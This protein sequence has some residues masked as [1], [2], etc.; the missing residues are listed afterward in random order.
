MV[1]HLRLREWM[2][3]DV[4]GRQDL[5]GDAARASLTE[6]GVF[7]PATAH[8]SGWLW[9]MLGPG[10]YLTGEGGDE[11]LGLRRTSPL[12]EVL[13]Y[14]V[15]G[16]RLPTPTIARATR[17]S[18]ATSRRRARHR[19]AQLLEDYG[20]A[21]LRPDARARLVDLAARG[22]ATEPWRA[23]PWLEQHLARRRVSI[24][25]HNVQ[26]HAASHGIAWKAPLLDPRF[27]AALATRVPWH[28]YRGRPILLRHHFADLLPPLLRERTTKATFNSAFFGDDTR[29]F[30]TTWDGS[31]LPASVDT[32]WLR[33]N[34][35][36][37]TPHAGTAMLLQR[38]WSA[39]C[40]GASNSPVA[41]T[42][43]GT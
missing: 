39:T 3:V 31:G 37:H 43:R 27:L 16:H 21:W 36:S 34:W 28:E 5:L 20:A 41:V 9:D 18:F 33:D 26:C 35:L 38:A 8:T 13:R 4:A 7:W 15:R 22:E 40:A 42:T 6:H 17:S 32:A 30:A 19:R 23:R 2:V 29:Q 25:L 24:G 14:A 10:T 1:S 12:A 11:V